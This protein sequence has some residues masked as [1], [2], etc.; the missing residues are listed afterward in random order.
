TRDGRTLTMIDKGRLTALDDPEV[1]QLAAKYGD[2]DEMLREDW[3]PGIPG[4]NMEGDYMR[5]YAPDPRAFYEKDYQR[6]YGDL[7]QQAVEE[8][9]P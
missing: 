4:I 3:I 2:P 5:D 9:G 6:V 8:Y 1:R 7:I